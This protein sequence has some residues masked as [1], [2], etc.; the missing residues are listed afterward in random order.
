MEALTQLRVVFL[1]PNGVD[2]CLQDF[3]LS[4]PVGYCLSTE[5]G[6][7]DQVQVEIFLLYLLDRVYILCRVQLQE[8]DC[9]LEVLVVE[10][11]HV[12]NLLPAS[13]EQVPSHLDELVP[14][15]YLIVVEELHF[16]SGLE[17]VAR[18]VI[19]RAILCRSPSVARRLPR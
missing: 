17:Q 1:F 3:S 8:S 4:C 15:E 18:V 9:L 2:V 14:C 11:P 19:P 13:Q 5:C 16:A 12:L 6:R 7:H 10:W